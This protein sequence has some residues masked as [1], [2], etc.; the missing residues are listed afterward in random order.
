MIYP[1]AS[2]AIVKLEGDGKVTLFTG[3]VEQGG[4]GLTIMAQIAAEE[5]CIGLD[6]I[7]IVS[8]DTETTPI[9]VGSFIGAAAY[10]TGNAV[11]AAAVDARRQLF[12]MA[13]AQLEADVDDLDTKDRWIYVKGS[14]DR[15]LSFSE[16]VLTSIHERDG[17]PI[18]GKGFYKVYPEADS[19]ANTKTGEGHYA[20]ALGF[21]ASVAEVEVNTKTGEVKVLN[22]TTAHDCGFCINPEG[23]EAQ[24]EG[25]IY[26]GH[27]IALSEQILIESGSV[28]NPSFLDYKAVRAPDI[29]KMNTIIVESM[30]PRSAYGCKEAGEAALPG[31]PAAIANAIYDAIGIRFK[32]YPITPE[33]ILEGLQNKGGES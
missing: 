15:G 9:D 13:A 24:I 19:Y 8:G 6:D 32:E 30:E 11:Q 14:P 27:G 16:A 25:Q 28:L 33:M 29:P 2:A 17:D 12:E 23:L 4:G 18:I 21:S 22:V 31:V 20:P 7:T 1:Y 10:C 3:M 5:L 26:M